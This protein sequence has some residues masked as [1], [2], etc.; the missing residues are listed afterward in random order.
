M[1]KLIPFLML[2]IA[3]TAIVSCGGK[4]G[5]KT[6]NDDQQAEKIGQ[7]TDKVST[8]KAIENAVK[9]ATGSGDKAEDG[10]FLRSNAIEKAFDALKAMGK[11]KDKKV[12]VFQDIHF[13]GDGRIMLSIADPAKPENV[14][15]YNYKDGEWSDPEPVKLS[16]GGKLSDN[17]ISLD[18][19]AYK[20][21]PDMMKIADEKAKSVEGGKASSHIFF[22]F[23]PTFNTKVFRT[24]VEG[25]RENY[26]L[27]F[28]K[29][30]KLQE[31]TKQ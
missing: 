15:Q 24:N 17:L 3:G 22:S 21:V 19:I 27:K 18:E 28:D 2:V 1:K 5:K 23:M 11:F 13:Y 4:T 29:D 14:D 30:G 25:A 9:S 31:Y 12:M 16:G 8:E 10:V 26:N 20:A 7:K 6:A